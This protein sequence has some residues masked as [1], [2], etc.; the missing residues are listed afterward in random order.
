M[1][2]SVE[3]DTEIF[4]EDTDV[5]QVKPVI[6]LK[7]SSIE[8]DTEIFTDDILTELQLK[9]KETYRKLGVDYNPLTGRA[10]D[11]KS[12]FVFTIVS[13]H[14]STLFNEN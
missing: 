8:F 6:K 4:R 14:Y 5:K 12:G 9:K 2:S 3:F 10:V 1:R 13:G 11:V 7:K